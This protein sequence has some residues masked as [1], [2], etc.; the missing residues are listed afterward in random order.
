MHDI[1]KKTIHHHIL[2]R[3]VKTKQNKP[4]RSRKF[5][6]DKLN[7]LQDTIDDLGWSKDSEQKSKHSMRSEIV[8]WGGRLLIEFLV[9]CLPF[10]LIGWALGLV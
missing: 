7:Y 8:L 4:P 2:E 9:F 6:N 5:K 1:D 10:L 3:K